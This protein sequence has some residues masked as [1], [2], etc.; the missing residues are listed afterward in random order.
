MTEGLTNAMN[1]ARHFVNGITLRNTTLF[2][3]GKNLMSVSTAI[4]HLYRFTI[5]EI[6]NE[7]TQERN[8]A[9]ARTAAKSFVMHKP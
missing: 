7:S 6:T 4:R 9:N 1:V 2:T 3:L 5:G 8:P